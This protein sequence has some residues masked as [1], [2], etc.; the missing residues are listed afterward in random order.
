MSPELRECILIVDDERSYRT[1]IK[2]V[3]VEAG[4][5][6]AEAADGKEALTIFKKRPCALA[7]LDLMMPHMDGKEL[8]KR[9]KALDAE[10]PVVFLTAHGSIASAVEAVKEGAADYLT[11]PLPHVDDLINTI[12]RVLD[13]AALRRHNVTLLAQVQE[14]DPFPACDTLMIALLDK[15]RKVAASDINVLITGESGTGKEKLAQFIHQSSPRS[16][17]P[18]VSLNCAAIVEN[19]LESELFGHEKGAF[20][21]A[22]ERRL[23]RFEEAHQST[24]FLDEI[25]E[26]PLPLQPKLLR[27]LQEREIR[28]VGGD[29]V[30]RF[31]ARLIVATNRDL[32]AFAAQGKFREDLFYRLSVVTLRLPA[33]RERPG[34]IRFL[35]GRFL[36]ET[37]RRFQKETP[38]LSAE[39]EQVL[40]G[41]TWPGNVRELANV[42][43]ASVLLCESGTIGPADLHG[44]E[45][46]P[47]AGLP[48]ASP[49]ETAE[50]QAIREALLK[51]SNHRGKTAEYL[52]MT[53]RNLLYKIKKYDL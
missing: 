5:E 53:T 4:F 7:L 12:R 13:H 36:A 40:T 8:M 51:C 1:L 10:L 30:I 25:G 46:A 29:R 47:A 19:L 18:M 42:I 2:S 37:A 27:A 34:D 26:M 23:G 43:E 15:A 14:K 49:L 35:A 41:Y 20:T 32:K 52:G 21:G 33:L 6:V 45:A 48:A 22:V 24:I 16:H 28:R 39:A 44:M 11:K 31:D 50:K 38:Q 9:L 3:L 17:R